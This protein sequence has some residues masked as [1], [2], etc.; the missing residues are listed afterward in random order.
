MWATMAPYLLLGFLLAGILYAYV[1]SQW[2]EKHL[3]KSGWSQIIKA[4][5]IGVPLPLCSCGVL[6][7]AMGIHKQGASR[8]STTAFLASTPQTGIDSIAA[9]LGMMG[10]VFA[11]VRVLVAFVTGIVT[12]L[13]VSIF[14]DSASPVKN[15]SMTSDTASKPGLRKGIRF[16]LVSLPGDIAKPVIFG[17]II[18]GVASALIPEGYLTEHIQSKWLS[19][20]LVTLFSVPL[21]VCSTG[22]IPLATVLITAGFSPGSALIFLIAGPATNAATI[23]SLWKIMSPRVT[24]IYLSSIILIAWASGALLDYYNTSSNFD[25]QIIHAH[26]PGANLFG[27]ISGGLLLILFL[28]IFKNSSRGHMPHRKD[29]AN[30]ITL[31]AE[32]MT[33]SNCA[34]HVKEALTGISGVHSVE[35]DLAGNSVLVSGDNLQRSKEFTRSRILSRSQELKSR[36]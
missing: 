3:G 28:N 8:A 12:G 20:L 22:S 17:I 7:V 34:R 18:A 24:V 33:C 2:V 35:V 6:P 29:S 4:T 26:G 9:T 32:N 25:I 21:Y 16:G 1:S 15:I 13:L 10:P 27:H 30:T 31:T 5:F 23:S 11:I 36:N 19:Y 14:G